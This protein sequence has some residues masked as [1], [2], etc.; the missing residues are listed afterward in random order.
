MQFDI[1]WLDLWNKYDD[2]MDDDDDDADDDLVNKSFYITLH[3][4]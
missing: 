1:H 2:V 3:I 4:E